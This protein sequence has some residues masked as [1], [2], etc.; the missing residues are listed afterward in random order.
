MLCKWRP[1]SLRKF[2]RRAIPLLVLSLLLGCD[3]AEFGTKA[4]E[5]VETKVHGISERLVPAD[6]SLRW[7]HAFDIGTL[8]LHTR[9]LAAQ[10]GLDAIEGLIAVDAGVPTVAMDDSA[11]LDNAVI[12]LNDI[13]IELEGAQTVATTLNGV[14]QSRDVFDRLGLNSLG[15]IAPLASLPHMDPQLTVMVPLT[16][17]PKSW[18]PA[19]GSLFSYLYQRGKYQEQNFQVDKAIQRYPSHV[20]QPDEVFA[21]SS[22]TCVNQ[23]KYFSAALAEESSFLNALRHR[24]TDLI[25]AILAR[26][27]VIDINRLH[28]TV[29]ATSASEGL[30]RAIESIDDEAASVRVIRDVELVRNQLYRD[31]QAAMAACGGS[32]NAVALVEAFDDDLSEVGI[33][34]ALFQ[35]SATL[36]KEASSAV[37]SLSVQV[38]QTRPKVAAYYKRASVAVCP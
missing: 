10:N 35:R 34:V 25:I 33:Q 20:L 8:D 22:S 21:V 3:D 23:R 18:L 6:L 7:L 5:F 24:H 27:R 30:S 11:K 15:V 1:P 16:T 2:R 32:S 19:I 13:Q 37:D 17:D 9:L 26:K 14:C 4:R 31:E 29:L 28:A 38:R 36:N 12:A